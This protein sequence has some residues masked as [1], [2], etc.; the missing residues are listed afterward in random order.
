MQVH[1]FRIKFVKNQTYHGSRSLLRVQGVE[2]S[3]AE[4]VSGVDVRGRNDEFGSR[5]V[6]LFG[7]K[8]RSPHFCGEPLWLSGKVVK[9]IKL[10]K[11]RGPGFAPHPLGNLFF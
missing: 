9:M 7:Q 2:V 1:F 5:A 4:R 11:S 8:I 3:A 6:A 10:M